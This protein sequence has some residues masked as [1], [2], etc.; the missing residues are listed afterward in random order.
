MTP[1]AAPCES[2]GA[3]SI[4]W[5][6]GWSRNQVIWLRTSLC[7]AAQI[8]A[9]RA[10]RSEAATALPAA[11]CDCVGWQF[12]GGT[13]LERW[14]IVIAKYPRATTQVLA[15]ASTHQVRCEIN[16]LGSLKVAL[17]VTH[18]APFTLH[19]QGWMYRCTSRR[20]GG[21]ENVP[22]MPA[23]LPLPMKPG[24]DGP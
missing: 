22:C 23:E 24:H 6:I 15:H 9:I 20:V 12:G 21:L 19:Q 8:N 3:T 4:Q 18:M 16:T 2:R 17:P 7:V 1:S 14:H 13:L 11:L 5:Y 10:T